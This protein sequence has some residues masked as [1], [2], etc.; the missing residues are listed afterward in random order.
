MVQDISQCVA[1]YLLAP[2]TRCC[3]AIT[4]YI[5]CWISADYLLLRAGFAFTTSSFANHLLDMCLLHAAFSYHLPVYVYCNCSAYYLLA[6]YV[7]LT[8]ALL[9]D[10]GCACA[11]TVGCLLLYSIS[12]FHL[13]TLLYLL[14]TGYCH[15]IQFCRC[16]YTSGFACFVLN[17]FISTLLA[18]LAY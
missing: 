1:H 16:T 9:I 11:F 8:Y 3:F 4:A 17:C 12:F 14:L 10:L 7:K 18:S 5:A 2:G 6:L 15:Y 13:R